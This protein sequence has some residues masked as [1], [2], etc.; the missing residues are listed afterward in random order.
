L[1]ERWSSPI[2]IDLVYLW[3]NDQDQELAELR[4][5]HAARY[6]TEGDVPY[7]L[8]PA[9]YRDNDELRFSL[10]TVERFAPFFRRIYVLHAGKAPA[11][12]RCDVP[13]LHLVPQA[14]LIPAPIW[15]SFNGEIAESYIP[16]LPG[17][18]EH[19]VFANDDNFFGAPLAPT[20][21]FDERGIAQT[22]VSYRLAGRASASTYGAMERRTAELIL[23]RFPRVRP[24]FRRP[25]LPFTSEFRAR[26]RGALPVNALAHV[27]HAYHR[28]L[29]HKFERDFGAEIALT[30]RQRFRTKEGL[31]LVLLY[32]HYARAQKAARFLLEK[33]P[34][35]LNRDQATPALREQFR[36]AILGGEL[37]R[38]CLNDTECA[39][40]DGWEAFVRELITKV[41]PNPSRWER[42]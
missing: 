25:W 31:T 27:Q 26:R 5:Y 39:G 40:D 28:S 19:Y 17:L 20:T 32:Q 12:L 36:K 15:P 34:V 4:R 1:Y 8:G 9:R 22:P 41:A 7:R 18:A 3:V 23:E 42:A 35:L 21:F 2:D 24:Y 33:R 16:H 13:G 10:R 6:Q 38:F 29:A 14:E 11:W 37:A 30:R